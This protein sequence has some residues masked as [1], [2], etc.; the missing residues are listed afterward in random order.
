M[1]SSG[2]PPGLAYAGHEGYL[3]LERTGQL[4]SE[5]VIKMMREGLKI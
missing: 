1:A 3:S 2:Y 5:D 4:T